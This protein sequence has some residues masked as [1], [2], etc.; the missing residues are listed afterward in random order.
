[1]KRPR[2]ASACEQ[3]AGGMSC[4]GAGGPLLYTLLIA[5]PTVSQPSPHDR[6]RSP[7]TR[8]GSAD[9]HRRGRERGR[10]RS[11]DAARK[12]APRR[13]PAADPGRRRAQGPRRRGGL[14]PP[15]VRPDR[16][17]GHLAG[18]EHARP[19]SGQDHLQPLPRRMG[20]VERHGH[21]LHVFQ[22]PR[23]QPAARRQVRHVER[24]GHVQNVLGRSRLQPA[25]SASTGSNARRNDPHGAP[26]GT[27]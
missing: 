27:R 6:R 20:Y 18:H 5:T 19:V 2:A 4:L 15:R 21:G 17:V 23:L 7:S 1:M 13:T 14:R 12:A 8:R 22:R 3:G 16:G 24:H 9:E 11:A 10:R 26:P 25:S